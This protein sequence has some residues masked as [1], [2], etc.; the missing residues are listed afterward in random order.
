MST[1]NAYLTVAGIGV[2][3]VYKHIKNMHISVYPP[4]GRVRVAAPERLDEDAIRLAIVQR[5]PWIKKQREQLQ[6]ADRQSEREMIAGESHYVWGQRLRLEIQEVSGRPHVDVAGSK[7]RLTVAADSDGAARR[8]ALDA[9]HRRQLKAAIPA[10]VEKWQ[11]LIGREVTGWTVRRMKTKWGSCNPD[12]GR[13]WFNV[14][15]AKKHPACLEYIVVH[16]MTHLHERTHN[17][18]F[19]ELMDKN[20]PNWRALRDELNGAPLADEEW[21]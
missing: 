10:L 6:A 7:L 18:R 15:L 16:E 1:A 17:D 2:D 13:L 3:V 11:P 14:E 8:K 5:L 21:K 19:V 12:S 4:R 20:L 9:W